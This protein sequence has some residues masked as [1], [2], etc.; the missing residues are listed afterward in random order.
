MKQDR[1]KWNKKY[2]EETY[3]EDV[4]AIVKRYWH[5]APKGRALD[6]AS[7]M[8]RNSLFLAERGFDVDAVDI[9]DRAT[10]DLAKRHPEIRAIRAD[11][12]Q[13]EIPRS[14]YGLILN[15]RF[16]NRRLFPQIIEGLVPGGILIFETGME[17]PE[18]KSETIRR[19]YLLRE[20]ELLHAFLALK[21]VCY[22]E[23]EPENNERQFPK[24][25]SLV[26]VKWKSVFFHGLPA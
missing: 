21:I 23:R 6:I 15:I 20:N 3:P 2:A 19:D 1:E 18:K 11:L 17:S 5:L 7:G 25:A 12:D 22:Q 13:F 10:D 26:A 24:V 16:L 9:S 14:T 4:S 8:G